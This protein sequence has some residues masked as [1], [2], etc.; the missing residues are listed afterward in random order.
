M[1]YL[2]WDAG[3]FDDTIV[4][5]TTDCIYPHEILKDRFEANELLSLQK[6]E[7]LDLQDV[8]LDVVRVVIYSIS[9]YS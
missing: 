3:G 2:P 6:S 7:A 8:E 5:G 1:A 9:A 4:F